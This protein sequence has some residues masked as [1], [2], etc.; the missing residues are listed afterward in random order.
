MS[1]LQTLLAR[2]GVRVA[3]LYDCG[4]CKSPDDV[5]RSFGLR[6]I[7]ESWREVDRAKAG[8]I[9]R[10]LLERDMAYNCEAESA[11]IADTTS[12]EFVSEFAED[13]KFFTNADWVEQANGVLNAREIGSWMPATDSTFDSGI[14]VLHTHRIGVCWLEDED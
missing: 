14:L 8:F 3:A 7:G 9:L 6:A 12:A 1:N 13:A 2:T 5:A 10:A 11:P 4:R